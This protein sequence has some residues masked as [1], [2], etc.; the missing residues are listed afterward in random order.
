MLRPK[1]FRPF[2]VRILWGI[3]LLLAAVGMVG[4]VLAIYRAD[5]RLLLPSAGIGGLAA[6]YV[7]AARRGRPL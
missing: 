6:L 1:K 5:W 4:T 2:E 3:A 7:L